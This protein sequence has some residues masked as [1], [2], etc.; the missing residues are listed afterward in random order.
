[1]TLVPGYNGK[2]IGLRV[3]LRKAVPCAGR[4]TRLQLL[5]FRFQPFSL[6]VC[7][8]AQAGGIFGT[9]L[10]WTGFRV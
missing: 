10:Q 8:C 7:F 2:V 6:E 9:R 3:S 1:M 4:R 5:G